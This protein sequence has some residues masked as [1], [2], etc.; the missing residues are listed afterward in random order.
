MQVFKVT[1]LVSKLAVAFCGLAIATLPAVADPIANTLWFSGNADLGHWGNGPVG[2][3]TNWQEF[4]VTDAAGWT[5]TDVYSLGD[6]YGG[7]QAEWSIRTGMAQGDG[8]TTIYGGTATINTGITFGSAQVIDVSVPS[9]YLA[10]GNYWLEVAPFGQCCGAEIW[11]TT[12]TGALNGSALGGDAS[13][14]YW[15]SQNQDYINAAF[16]PGSQYGVALSEG[17]AGTVGAPVPEPG[18]ASLLICGF[19]CVMAGTLRLR[20]A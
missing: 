16:Y 11:A 6:T 20:R 15:P 13:L 10:P 1:K 5:L 7:T 14:R 4:T 17:V 19:G 2:G 18:T 12:G 8:G 3:L 9:I